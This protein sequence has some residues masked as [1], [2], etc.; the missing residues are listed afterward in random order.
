M[1]SDIE[2][3]ETLRTLQQYQAMKLKGI[4]LN[5]VEEDTYYAL[6]R[7]ASAQSNATSE[8]YRSLLDGQD[9]GTDTSGDTVSA[10]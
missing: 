9:I 2:F 4:T 7:R 10:E 8:A 5:E 3:I 6:C 1:N